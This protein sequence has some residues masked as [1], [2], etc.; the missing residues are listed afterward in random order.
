MIEEPEKLIKGLQIEVSLFENAKGVLAIED[1]KPDCIK[2]LKEMV[3]D[4]PE[5]EVQELVTKYPQGSERSLIYAVTGRAINSKMLPADAGCIVNNV[6]TVI[7]IYNA[8]VDGK[9]LMDR[10]VTVTGDAIN[11]PAN[12]KVPVGTLYTELLNASGG[13]SKKPK[14][15]IS[16]G[17]M[18]GFALF[19]TDI[20]VTK[21][22]SALLCLSK[23]DVSECKKT[24]CINCGRCVDACPARLIPGDL[25]DFAN[26]FDE[27]SFLANYGLECVECGSCSFVCPARRYLAQSIKTMRKVCLAKKKK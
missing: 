24:Q 18:M 15:I 11:E 3:K 16:G 22:S 13:Y 19:D 21:S 5:V 7:S 8:V 2:L 1:N 23:D 27:E 25:A 12:Y 10:I 6:D 14:K 20:P 4:I 26:N 17:P 9:P